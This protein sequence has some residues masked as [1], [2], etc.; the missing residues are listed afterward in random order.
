MKMRYELLKTNQIT[1]NA[2][3]ESKKK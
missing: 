1:S 2:R 3:E